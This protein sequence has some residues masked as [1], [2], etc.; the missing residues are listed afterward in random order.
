MSDQLS[1]VKKWSVMMTLNTVIIF[2]NL[3][4]PMFHVIFSYPFTPS[5]LCL[6]LKESTLNDKVHHEMHEV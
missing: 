4:V 2:R 5:P 6:S 1:A 3:S